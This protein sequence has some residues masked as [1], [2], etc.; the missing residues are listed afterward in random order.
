LGYNFGT[1][2]TSKFDLSSPG[3]SR[4]AGYFHSRN[5]NTIGALL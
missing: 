2:Q 1:F 4:A 3:R 5:Y